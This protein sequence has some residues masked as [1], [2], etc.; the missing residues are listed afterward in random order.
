MSRRGATEIF[1]TA[2]FTV[3]AEHIAVVSA[4]SEFAEAE[5]R[6][7]KGFMFSILRRGVS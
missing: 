2:T 5:V 3:D 4:M 7:F 1:E 6:L